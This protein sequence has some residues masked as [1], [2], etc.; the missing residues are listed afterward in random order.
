PGAAGR[1][2]HALAE[3]EADGSAF[4]IE[5]RGSPVGIVD[6][7]TD[8]C[9]VCGMCARSC[10]TEALVLAPRDGA[11]DITFEGLRCT[12]C[13]QCVASCPEV[14]RGAI[15]L[16]R[17]A[18]RDVLSRGPARLVESEVAPCLACGRQVAPVTML[19]RVSELLGPEERRM[20]RI[21]ESYC[22]DCRA[23]GLPVTDRRA[24]RDASQFVELAGH[25]EQGRVP[26]LLDKR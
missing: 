4:D 18:S 22:S 26:E 3:R 15:G 13:G 17:H 16:R 12:G 6:I 1:V 7:R 5:H 23:V 24:P 19:R 21:L 11:V 14:N 25:V 8:S 20:T 10:P 2:L 9:T